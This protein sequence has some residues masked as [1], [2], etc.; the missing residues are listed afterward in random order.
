MAHLDDSEY[1][2]DNIHPITH[3]DGTLVMRSVKLYSDGIV[4]S[5]FTLQCSFKLDLAKV[6]WGALAQHYLNHIRTTTKPAAH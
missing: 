4:A 5:S 2:G 1:W 6:P 3:P